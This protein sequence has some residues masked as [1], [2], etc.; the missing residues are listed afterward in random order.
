MSIYVQI[1]LAFVQINFPTLMA[2]NSSRYAS[3]HR[4]HGS[5]LL[6][7]VK[8]TQTYVQITFV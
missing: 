8:I 7:Y 2:S 6:I 4:L 1:A 3:L 5:T